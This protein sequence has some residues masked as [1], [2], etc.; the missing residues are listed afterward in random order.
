MQAVNSH[1]KWLIEENTKIPRELVWFKPPTAPVIRLTITTASIRDQKE[2][3][4]K[5]TKIKGL[6][7][8][9]VRSRYKGNHD[10]ES[11]TLNTHLWKGP[12]PNLIAKDKNITHDKTS[13]KTPSLVPNLDTTNTTDAKVCTRKYLIEDSEVSLFLTS[14]IKGI[15]LSVFNSRATQHISNE[16]LDINNNTLIVKTV[17]NITREGLNNIGEKA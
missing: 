13:V 17:V 9:T 10:N 14:V 1:P 15:K 16:G 12:A 8:W 4:R 6:I 3:V 7:F 11:L 5:I 2:S